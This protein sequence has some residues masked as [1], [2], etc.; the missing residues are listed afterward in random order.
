MTTWELPS[1]YGRVKPDVVTFGKSIRGSKLRGEQLDNY[2]LAV[3]PDRWLSILRR[4]PS[5][6]R[7]VCGV[8]C[9][10][11]RCHAAGERR[12]RGIATP[13]R[14]SWYFW[15]VACQRFA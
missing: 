2:Q 4:L 5:A 11:R 13:P 10:R 8:A 7:H 1:G 6:V 9:G 3:G 12:A 15:L 14:Q